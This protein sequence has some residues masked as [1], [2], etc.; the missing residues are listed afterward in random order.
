MSPQR[1]LVTGGAGFLGSHL[2]RAVLRDPGVRVVNLDLLTYAG[3][4]TRLADVEDGSRYRFEQADV[5]D[6]A[7][8]TR[9]IDE[10]TP[11]AVVHFAAESHVTRSER[12][13]ER[14]W[15]TNVEGTKVMLEAAS[16]G[17]VRRFV[18]IST[19]E[20][21]GPILDGAFQEE[22]K[23]TGT[24]QATSPYARSKAQ[25]DDLASG[26]RSPMEVVVVRPTNGFGPWQ[27][28]EKALARWITRALR[29][30][31]IPVWGDGGHVR[32][33]LAAEDLA[34]ALGLI[35]RAD[36]LEPIYNVGPRH[37]PEITNLELARWLVGHMGLEEDRL[38]MTDY[39]RPDHDRR[40][41]VVPDRIE[42]L[43][44]KAGDPFERFAET[45]DWYRAH[46]AWWRPLV[47]EAESI[48]ADDTPV[49]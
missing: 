22:D 34:E 46:E 41:A 17:G 43:G 31:P 3:S 7:A 42:A 8:V 49:R 27:F 11:D 45:V 24:G 38:V 37:D 44:W 4:R 33:W 2:I 18:H 29:G 32:Q 1:I 39:D 30:E 20:V 35:L 15:R 47:D 25:A 23:L 40:Y 48:Y 6:P 9:V 21:Y 5:A 14:F 16:R 19:D 26:I 28:P 36:H 12:D 10:D 13:S